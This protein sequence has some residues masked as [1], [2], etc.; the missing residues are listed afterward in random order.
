MKA[1]IPVVLFCTFAFFL[2]LSG[3]DTAVNRSNFKLQ[4]LKINQKIIIILRMLLSVY[5]KHLSEKVLDVMSKYFPKGQ[6]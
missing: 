2:P 1:T 6:E 3:Q 5:V 4:A